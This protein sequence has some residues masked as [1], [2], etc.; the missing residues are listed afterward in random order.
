MITQFKIVSLKKKK[1]IKCLDMPIVLPI[2]MPRVEEFQQLL[3]VI[4]VSTNVSRALG[5]NFSLNTIGGAL[6]ALVCSYFTHLTRSSTHSIVKVFLTPFSKSGIRFFVIGSFHQLFLLQLTP[7]LT[8]VYPYVCAGAIMRP[9][10]L[11]WGIKMKKK[12]NHTPG[13]K[14]KRYFLFKDYF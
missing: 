5:V 13:R 1:K 6:G 2:A 3:A 11:D 4:L 12:K 10:D 7:G 9:T 8:A 14:K